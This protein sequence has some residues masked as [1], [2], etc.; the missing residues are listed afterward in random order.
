M[1]MESHRRNA[2]HGLMLFAIYFVFYAG[3]VLLAA[4]SPA[5]MERTPLAG[6]NLAIWYGFGL[7]VVAL[8]LAL[9]YGWLCRA[10]RT[11]P[12]DGR[13]AIGGDR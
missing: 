1:T 9:I 13:R 2:R 5:T 6:V 11:E 10:E 4:F 8:A 12:A 3:F 7:I